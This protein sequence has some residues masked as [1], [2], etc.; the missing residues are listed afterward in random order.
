MTDLIGPRR[1]LSVASVRR[2]DWAKA[3]S[4]MSRPTKRVRRI[5]T[6][7]LTHIDAGQVVPELPFHLKSSSTIDMSA[8]RLFT[9]FRGQAWICLMWVFEPTSASVLQ[10][11]A[12]A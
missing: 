11:R 1:F 9:T 4:E 3:A 8:R 12:T 10:E 2:L 5:M 7:I 6:H